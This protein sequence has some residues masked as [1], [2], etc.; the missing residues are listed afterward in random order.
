MK[1]KNTIHPTWDRAKCSDGYNARTLHYIYSRTLNCGTARWSVYH[2]LHGTVLL[3]SSK[4][5]GT[6]VLKAFLA[7]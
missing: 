6:S 4:Q 2:M 3:C 7:L 1:D 5:C